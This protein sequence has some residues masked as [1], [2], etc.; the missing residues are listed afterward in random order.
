MGVR[1]GAGEAADGGNSNSSACENAKSARKAE[2]KAKR[3]QERTSCERDQFDLAS[4]HVDVCITTCARMATTPTTSRRDL[5]R[6]LEAI[7]ADERRTNTWLVRISLV[8]LLAAWAWQEYAGRPQPSSRG[9]GRTGD[10]A[11]GA[12]VFVWAGAA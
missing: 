4:S 11:G 10:E 5:Q 9:K 3:N 6:A 2:K 8:L 1:R 7:G 12:R